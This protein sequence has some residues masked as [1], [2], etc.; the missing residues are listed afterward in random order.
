MMRMTYGLRCGGLLRFG[1]SSS[2]W[3]RNLGL[4][5][6]FR[7]LWL[8]GSLGLSS[9]RLLCCCGL[10]GSGLLLGSLLLSLWLLGLGLSDS[11]LGL[12]LGELGSS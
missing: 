1:C 6:S 8:G 5:S 3:L 9:G 7:S 10:L 4:S 2:L 12:L 11:W